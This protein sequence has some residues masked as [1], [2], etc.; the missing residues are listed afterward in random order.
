MKIKKT[1][2]TKDIQQYVLNTAIN[3]LHVPIA[4]DVGIFEVITLG[5]HESIQG[6]D[7]RITAIFENDFIMA[8]FADRYATSQFE[9]YVPSHSMELYDILGAGGAIGVVKSKNASLKDVEPTKI[10][11]I[12]YCCDETGK[13]IN[14]KWYSKQRVPFS[15]KVP[16]HAKIILSVG[17]TMDS[18]KTTTA[19]FVARGLKLTGK[20]VA[21]IK[22]TGTCFTKDKDFVFDCGADISTDFSDIGFPSTF[23][24]EKEDL[25]DLYQTL[26]DSIAAENPDYI[27]MEI[28]D[29]LMQRETNFLLKTRAFMA[30]IYSVVFSCGD[31]LSAFQ[32]YDILQQLGITPALISGRFTMS[33][34]LIE[35]VK[36]NCAVPVL[37][38]DQIMTGKFNNLLVSARLV[39]A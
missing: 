2:V 16:N 27:V 38:I 28:A 30:T 4:G 10:R 3:E 34:L 7:K 11:L 23:M 39:A 36:A 24:C 20:K 14:T 21:F 12:G 6:E 25:L 35:E 15:G 19:A 29:G 8:A 5:R 9:G 32:G 22:F 33:P 1:I 37:T 26:L 31:S 18:G 17:S 13:V